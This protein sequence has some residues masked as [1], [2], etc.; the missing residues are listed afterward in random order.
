MEVWLVLL[1]GLLFVIFFGGLAMVRKEPMPLRFVFE[2][3]G[4]TTL[5]YLIYWATSYL[6]SPV[7]FLLILYIVTMRA[8]ILTDV[9]T[10][11]A[12]RGN[13]GMA[14]RFYSIAQRVGMGDSAKCVAQINIGTCYLKQ[15][16]FKESLEVL[17]AVAELADKGLMGPKH[18]AA[19]RYN[20]GL[21]LMRSGHTAEAVHQL[22]EVEELLPAS[23]YGVG[24]R[25]ELK[26]Y[27][28]A[29]T[30]ADGEVE[31]APEPDEEKS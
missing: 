12:R 21:A 30:S 27:R 13:F 15:G 6:V 28:K 9:G 1:V 31:A 3:L 29:A 7:V 20:L 16:R 19:C 26:R 23:M 25:A 4:L 11:L 10:F 8:Q 2:C 22:S 18:E 5:A 24:A 14:E 17:R